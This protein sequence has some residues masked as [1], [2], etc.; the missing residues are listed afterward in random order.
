MNKA[1]FEVEGLP[2]L[3]KTLLEIP[4]I[5][6]QPK[7]T[8]IS[9]YDERQWIEIKNSLEIKLGIQITKKNNSRF[10]IDS[11]KFG[12]NIDFQV[13]Y[14]I[15]SEELLDI[16]ASIIGLHSIFKNIAETYTEGFVQ[17]IPC[18]MP[19]FNS[20]IL[21]TIICYCQNLNWN[22]NAAILR[23]QNNNIEPLN[24]VYRVSYFNSVSNHNLKQGCFKLTKMI[25][26]QPNIHFL[27]IEVQFGNI[28]PTYKAFLNLNNRPLVEVKTKLL[29]K[30]NECN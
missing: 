20:D 12:I 18:D 15:H 27:P 17:I 22:L 14:D 13:V 6:T 25:C 19:Y 3:F 21:N 28:D 24:S 29:V 7:M 2:I 4:K 1:L 16:R 30:E 10:N 23:W 5:N 9:C 8:Y 26:T 11:E